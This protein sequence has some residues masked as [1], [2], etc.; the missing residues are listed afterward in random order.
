VI[1]AVCRHTH[2][3]LGD[4]G[5]TSYYRQYSRLHGLCRHK[6]V[7][8]Y[9]NSRGSPCTPVACFAGV[10]CRRRRVPGSSGTVAYPRLG[11]RHN[12]GT[13]KQI[14][15]QRWTSA[16]RTAHPPRCKRHPAVQ[17]RSSSWRATAVRAAWQPRGL[18][19]DRSWGGPLLWK[20]YGRSRRG[21]EG[22][23]H[24]RARPAL[25]HPPTQASAVA[26]R[27]TRAWRSG[28][29]CRSAEA[30][31]GGCRGAGVSG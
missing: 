31:A 8:R 6:A 2:T 7:L 28:A 21:C 3:A 27:C 14:C 26:L 11:N 30:R 17:P 4:L 23:R 10:G 24:Q 22:R 9:N 19:V 1:R 5:H 13:P 16:R 25:A 18:Y 15:D 12:R 20:T 29:P